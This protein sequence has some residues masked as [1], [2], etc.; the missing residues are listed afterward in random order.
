MSGR[1]SIGKKLLVALLLGAAVALCA[2]KGSNEDMR[3]VDVALTDA[4]GD[5]LS[6]A[7]DVTSLSLTKDD[8]TTVETLPQRTRVDLAQLNDLSE[9]VAGATIPAGKYLGATLGLDYSGADIRVDDGSGAPVPVPLANIRDPLGNPVT[10]LSVKV[11]LD[12]A[13]PLS[14][15]PIGVELLDL[16]FNLAASNTVDMSVPASPVVTVSPLLVADVDPASP[17][18]H[19]IRGPLDSVAGAGG[20]SGAFTLVLRPFN[21][22]QGDHGRLMFRTDAN[23][24]FEINQAQSV[25][26]AGLQALAQLPRLTAVVAVGTLV[27][28]T[29][30]FLATEVRAGTS[31]ALGTDDVLTGNVLSRSGNVLTVKGAELVRSDG[32][33]IFRD[34]VSVTVGAGT[35]VLKE[36]TAGTFATGD[37]SVG[38]RI[39]ALGTLDTP[40]TSMTSADLVR[41]LVTQLNGTASSVAGATVGMAVARIDSRPVGLFNFAGTGT[42]GNDADPAAYV[43]ATGGLSLAGIAN[44]TPLKV[45]GFP[46]PLGTAGAAGDFNATT[47]TDVTR[48]PATLVV[49]WPLLEPAP[50]AFSAGGMTLNLANAGLLHDVIRDGVDTRLLTTDAPLVQTAGQGGLFVIGANGTVQVFTQFAAY[51]QA[52]QSGLNSGLKARSFF[53]AGGTGS[54]VDAT[55]TLTAATMA[56]ALQ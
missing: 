21:L 8:G 52:L 32:T 3:A 31:V 15:S 42:P 16:D 4:Q 45:R 7:V 55:K 12:G 24:A 5:F 28:G 40:A 47:L 34:T 18:P 2:C 39:T 30:Q 51:Q 17:K 41:L 14:I 49:G 22:A 10:A 53:A 11:Q 56:T 48:S 44:G 6:Y 43:V 29:R 26:T 13:K 23:T 35:K 25:G 20:A 46:A 9:F 37:I 33:L 19:R 27:P 54:Y 36:A 50:F 1:R 38:Q